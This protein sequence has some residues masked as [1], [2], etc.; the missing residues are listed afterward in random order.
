MLQNM[1][2][3][4][5][6]QRKKFFVSLLHIKLCPSFVGFYHAKYFTLSFKF[7]IC[8]DWSDVFF[9]HLMYIVQYLGPQTLNM[10]PVYFV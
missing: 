5:S 8:V 3:F 7:A 2:E 9:A 1:F 10:K 4:E 6:I